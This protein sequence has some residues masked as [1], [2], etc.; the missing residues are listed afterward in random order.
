MIEE[1]LNLLE[2]LD[3]INMEE[4]DK[5][6]FREVIEKIS[7]K[8]SHVKYKKELAMTRKKMWV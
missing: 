6:I 1:N 2:G 3:M 7:N 4:E 8:G 5:I